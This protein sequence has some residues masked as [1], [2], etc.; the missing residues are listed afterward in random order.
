MGTSQR[1]TIYNAGK[2]ALK[3]SK[4]AKFECYMSEA[5]EHIALQK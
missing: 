2:R 4:L 1:K 3:I 5:R